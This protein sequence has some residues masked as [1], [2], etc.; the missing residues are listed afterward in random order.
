MF[1]QQQTYQ[2]L[3]DE[4]G[5]E[6]GEGEETEV[7]EHVAREVLHV[8]GTRDVEIVVHSPDQGHRHEHAEWE[9]WVIH[10]SLGVIKMHNHTELKEC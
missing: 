9:N 5:G 4:D 6:L 1:L 2:E 10:L 8:Q 7:E 3:S